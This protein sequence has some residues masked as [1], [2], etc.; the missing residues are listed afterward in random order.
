MV[1]YSCTDSNGRISLSLP[2]SWW[3]TYSCRGTQTPTKQG[4]VSNESVLKALRAL[5]DLP[6][7]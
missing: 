6:S 3:F 5:G 4:P 1:C 7:G 2:G